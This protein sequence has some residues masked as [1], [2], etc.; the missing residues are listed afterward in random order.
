M[1]RPPETRLNCG[2]LFYGIKFQYIKALSGIQSSFYCHVNSYAPSGYRW[3]YV[4]SPAC[5]KLFFKFTFHLCKFRS[6][7]KF[8][9][10]YINILNYSNYLCTCS[11]KV[12]E[13]RTVS[14]IIHII[15][16]QS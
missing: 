16:L 2:H 15:D 11:L 6:S 7:M 5:Y 9:L 14:T 12:N 13:I 1:E 8:S 4:T 10:C 3:S